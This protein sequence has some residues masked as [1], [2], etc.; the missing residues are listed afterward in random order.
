MNN[1]T[2]SGTVLNHEGQPLAGSTVSISGLA[3]N[4]DA[5]GAFLLPELA[6]QNL[7]L[8]ISHVDY[9]DEIIP[10]HLLKP[11]S[12]TTHQLNPIILTPTDD[13]ST[14]FLFGGDTIFGRRYIDPEEIT[15][16]NQVPQ[17]DPNALISVNDPVPGSQAV[18][19]YIRP[20]YQSVDWGVVNLE[21]PVTSNTSTPHETKRFTFFTLPES[22]QALVWLGV[23]Y[24]SLGNNHLYDYQDIG[25]VDTMTHL[26][27][28]G[29]HY[30]G[31]GLNS[32][33]AYQSHQQTING[34]AYSF[35]SMTSVTGNENEINFVA[36]DN[37]GGAANLNDSSAL[38]SALQRDLNNNL[39]PIAQLHGGK[40]YT[41]E[42]TD[43]FMEQIEFA[44][45]SGAKLVV[46]HHPHIAQ[47][48][49]L[50]DDV[51]T[52]HSLGN[53]VFDQARLET[54]L[55]LVAR[56]DLRTDQIP[57]VRLYPVYIDDFIPKPIS[58]DLANRFLRRI[59]EFSNS[60]GA[61]VYPYNN[62][63]WVAFDNNAATAID[64]TVTVNVSVPDTG[65][66]LVDLRQ[67]SDSS[68]SLHNITT[69]IPGIS[70]TIGRDILSHGDFEDWDIDDAGLV[71]SRW[72]TSN[73]SSEIC[74][75]EPYKGLAAL[76]STRHGSNDADSVIPFRNRIRI[77]GESTG[78]P[79]KALS[80]LTYALGKNSGSLKIVS[81]FHASIDEL[82]FGEEVSL[83][84]PGG[85]FDWQPLFA[86]INMPDDS[87][88]DITDVTNNPRSIQLFISQ[89]PPN[90]NSALAI[91]DEL[92]VI[93]WEE[94]L[95][96]EQ[97]TNL[98][99]PHARDFLRVEGTPGDY[100][101]SLTL[102]QYQPTNSHFVMPRITAN[103]TNNLIANEQSN[104]TVSLALQHNLS[105]NPA[106][107]WWISAT[108]STGEQFS[109]VY[110]EGWKSGEL[111]TI[112]NPL[113]DIP[114]FEIFNGTLAKG[115][116]MLNFCIDNNL[117]NIK[118]CTW[119][120]SA[121]IEIE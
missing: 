41:F 67:L 7:L 65:L 97:E 45:S 5:Q 80:V 16:R 40:E 81:R 50:I 74:T 95:T 20:L 108:T 35:L 17:N 79:N 48:V 46:G 82:T 28:V 44:V 120:D 83:Q 57:G 2:L 84:H 22:M 118:N 72:D 14:R 73:E 33:A 55:G 37:K 96:L 9:R 92:A 77:M 99:T 52:I 91:F 26:D 11:S 53:L 69:N 36:S 49:G 30:S 89:S 42:P 19:Q 51:V 98:V 10:V 25:V 102:R 76:C 104:I 58:G 27:T 15:P 105:H 86:D 13:Q 113:L 12:I 62:Q 119:E 24:V 71:A 114:T 54:M 78:E 43:L 23:D 107:D 70:V 109:Y 39:T 66:T 103:E 68:A 38:A 59:G 106:V 64:H 75:N 56:V 61:L 116:Y 6:R 88:E 101:L 112:A 21:T 34:T 18:L 4:T 111:R 87:T 60:Y 29:I 110:P 3:T 85:S 93:N 31:A 8:T 90:K 121:T 117:D 32:N 100:Q 47:G 1:I 94:Q 115:N 63:G